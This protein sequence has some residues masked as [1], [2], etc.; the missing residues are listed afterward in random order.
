MPDNRD[1]LSTTVA[2]SSNVPQKTPASSAGPVIYTHH[3]G[4]MHYGTVT[5]H[6][7]KEQNP[8]DK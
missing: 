2:V 3:D 5:T 1:S 7:P 6:N 8:G 4:I